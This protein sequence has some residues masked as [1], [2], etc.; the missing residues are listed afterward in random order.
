[1][2]DRFTCIRETDGLWSVWDHVLGVPAI[3]GGCR[4]VG[5]DEARARAAC[6]VLRRIYKNRL[7]RGGIAPARETVPAKW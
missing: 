2:S 1:M 4:L 7:D 6:D 3:L 5:R